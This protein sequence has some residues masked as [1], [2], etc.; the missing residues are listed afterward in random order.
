MMKLSWITEVIYNIY[1]SGR[2]KEGH[3]LDF[4]DFEQLVKM[5]NATIMRKIYFELKANGEVFDYFGYQMEP[6]TFALPP[7]DRR[8]RRVLKFNDNESVVRLP[9]GLG[10]FDIFPVTDDESVGIK[11]YPVI[12]GTNS[13]WSGEDFDDIMKFENRGKMITFYNVPECVAEVEIDGIFN[14]VDMD[15]PLDTAI[16]IINIVLVETLKTINQPIDKTDDGDPNL[17]AVK[18]KIAEKENI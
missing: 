15:V 12:A 11:I 17:L 6:K 3:K 13:L 7:K 5:A 2:P 8:G 18:Q 14:D 16:D 9:A 10:I 1:Y 4:E